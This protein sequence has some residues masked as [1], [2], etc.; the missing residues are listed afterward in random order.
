MASHLLVVVMFLAT[1]TLAHNLDKPPLYW[2]TCDFLLHEGYPCETYEVQTVDNYILTM[3]RIPHGK[4]NSHVP[5]PRPVAYL[6]HGIMDSSATWVINHP[7]IS[8][9]FMLADR[10]YDVWMGNNRGN[11]YSDKHV[12]LTTKEEKFWEF[13]FHELGEYDLPALIWFVLEKTGVEQISYI[14]HSQGTSQAFVAF[15]RN[16]ELAARIKVFV[17]LAP[18]VHLGHAK[19]LLRFLSNSHVITQWIMHL[20]GTKD[21]L[22]NNWLIKYLASKVCG[23][24]VSDQ[25]CA[26]PLF[27]IVGS[28]T[29][30]IDMER[31]P[32]YL[33]H[34][35]AGTSMRSLWHYSQLIQNGRFEQYD[36]GWNGNIQHYHQP[37]P[38][39]YHLVDMKVPTAIF[40]GDLDWL[41]T[42]EDTDEYLRHGLPNLLAYQRNEHWNHMD[43]MWARNAPSTVYEKVFKLLEGIVP[44]DIDVRGEREVVVVE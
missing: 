25:V 24:K 9:G 32:I 28:N 44:E 16:Q 43:F 41:S 7:N 38:P 14:G 3:H 33:T 21:F 36:F 18:V 6:Q 17:A 29:G 22:P 42:A 26:D 13:S 10:G 35:P 30:N 31:M 12:T 39:A 15:S 40:T 23:H 27:L 20:L 11:T 37:T 4:N 1:T 34:T 19:G 2:R 8:L 5:G